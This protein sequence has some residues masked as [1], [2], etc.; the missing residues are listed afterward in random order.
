MFVCMIHYVIHACFVSHVTHSCLFLCG[1]HCYFECSS[2]SLT[3]ASYYNNFMY[4]KLSILTSFFTEYAD[5]LGYTI[6]KR[7]FL[8]LLDEQL[9]VLP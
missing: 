2:N 3:F 4:T 8:T 1:I 7:N 5:C 6:E 9:A